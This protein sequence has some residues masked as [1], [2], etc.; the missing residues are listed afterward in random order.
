[1]EVAE[2]LGRLHGLI[3]ELVAAD[4]AAL[5]SDVLQVLAEGLQR[6]QSRLAVA[7]ADVLAVWEPHGGWR[8]SRARTAGGSSLRQEDGIDHVDDPVGRLEVGPAHGRATDPLQRQWQRFEKKLARRGTPRLPSEGPADYARRAALAH[9]AASADIMAIGQR[10]A[11]LRYGKTPP[12][13]A[14]LTALTTRINRLRIQ[15]P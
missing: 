15:C 10:Y 13:G 11:A 5:D 9:P 3:D 12:G 7:A 2:V 1:M 4:V 6:E 8:A 14:A